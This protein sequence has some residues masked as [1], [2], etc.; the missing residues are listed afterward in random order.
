MC[1]LH[2]NG[3]SIVMDNTTPSNQAIISDLEAKVEALKAEIDAIVLDQRELT[4]AT[5]VSEFEELI[6]GKAKVMADL[7]IGLQLQKALES[8]ALKAETDELVKSLPTRIKN[9]GYRSIT[10]RM[11]GGTKIELRTPYY[12]RKATLKKH[13]GKRGFYA[14]LIL[15]GIHE[16]CTPASGSMISLLATASCSFDE[17]SKLIQTLL[18][19]SVNVKTIRLICKR[20]ALR[21]RTCQEAD[22]FDF[23][24]EFS[25]RLIAA[26]TDGGRVRIRTN[27][28]GR[29]T[30]K[31]R[32]RYKTD[33][34]EP[35][36]IIIYVVG[37]NGEK[38]RRV[39]PIMDATFAGPDSAFSM[40]IYY[41]KKLKVSLADKL[42]FI[43]D[44][45]KWI[46][47]RANKLAAT[48]GINPSQ[49]YMALDYYHAVEH[50]S[51]LAKLKN[52][53]AKEHKKWV[54]KQK[55]RLL[56]GKLDLFMA[57][58]TSVCKGA[59]NILIK[60]E[61]NYFKSHLAH[62]DYANLKKMGL[63]IGSGAVES[64]IRRV[65]NM[66]LKGPGIFW[67]EDTADAMLMMRSY[68]KAG[69][70]SL[71]KNMAYSGGLCLI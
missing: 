31:N 46:W 67:H 71:L 15:L 39:A 2:A 55:K 16:R 70:W 58:I 3:R 19:Y 14:G 21:A 5:Q 40:L 59:K 8:D 30:K 56:K 35:K 53:N 9:M 29:K 57:E 27:K 24:E 66:R 52:W 7:I 47:E 23:G 50:L 20:F 25:G 17:A 69:R 61:K 4:N 1:F 51:D 10:I 48:I 63:P 38:D 49:C 26:S 32:T 18:G 64:G 34:R 45:A 44:G 6:H 60:R 54:N 62:M 22:S 43:S 13:G 11:L 12:H 42:L 28:R 36:L 37:E 33:W 68:Y 65:V 41:L